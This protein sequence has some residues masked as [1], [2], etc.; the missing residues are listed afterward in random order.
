[1][2]RFKQTVEVAG[3]TYTYDWLGNT[4]MRVEPPGEGLA[5]FSN[6]PRPLPEIPGE[7]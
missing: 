5:L 1:V 7:Q 4:V 6:A 3:K 2:T